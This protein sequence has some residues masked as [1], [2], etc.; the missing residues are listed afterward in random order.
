MSDEVDRT[1][2]PIRRP[3]FAGVAVADGLANRVLV[4][5]GVSR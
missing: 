3:P 4:S 5:T 1:V 2:L